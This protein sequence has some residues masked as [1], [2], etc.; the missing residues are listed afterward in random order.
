MIKILKIPFDAG[1]PTGAKCTSKSPNKIANF[2]PKT[3]KVD[4]QVNQSNAEETQKN[5]EDVALKEFQ[6]KN[7]IC[8]I[9]GDHSITYGL[10]KA[11]SK[12]HKDLSLIYFD[13]HLDCEDEFV[14]PS[15]EDVIKA[16]VNNKIIKP[17]NIVIIGVR[18]FWKKEV[19]FIKKHNIEVI[20]A[21]V[22]REEIEKYIKKF[23]REHE[24][25]YLSI[26]IDVFDPSVAPDTGYPEKGGFTK[27]EFRKFTENM[28]FKR[29][30]GFDVV[31]VAQHT[32]NNKKTVT[33][34]SD[35]I[36]FL[37]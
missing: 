3:K 16:I 5:I 6:D 37:L 10:V 30:I 23:F 4:I 35:V 28:N 34:A 11:A 26:D 12:V 33:L 17:E 1:N 29:I 9:G 19:D 7:K 8:A 20:Y 21:P 13:A 14:P 32:V 15:H 25:I 36:K 2:F 24:K 18:K 22:K 31:E 27:E